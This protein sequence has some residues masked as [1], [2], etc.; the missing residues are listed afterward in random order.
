MYDTSQIAFYMRSKAIELDSY[1]ARHIVRLERSRPAKAWITY[2]QHMIWTMVYEYKLW[3][4]GIQ[5]NTILLEM[6][7]SRIKV[8]FSVSWILDRTN[9]ENIYYVQCISILTNITMLVKA[10]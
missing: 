6:L 5:D 10:V 9:F 8:S 1:G 4:G 3:Y 2:M 7:G